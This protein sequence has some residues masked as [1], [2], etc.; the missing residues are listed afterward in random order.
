LNVYKQPQLMSRIVDIESFLIDP[1][2]GFGSDH[3]HCREIGS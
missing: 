1:K 3:G 2:I